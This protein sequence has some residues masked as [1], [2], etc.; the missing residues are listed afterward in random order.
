MSRFNTGLTYRVDARAMRRWNLSEN[1]LPPDTVVLF[2]P[3]SMW[4]QH[5]VFISLVVLVVGL[6]SLLM[7][8]LLF[9]RRRRREAE[10]SLRDSEARMTFTAEIGATAQLQK[11]LN[12]IAEVSGVQDA[13]RA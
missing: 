5:R 1:K 13:R 4:Q 11:A 12:A 9:Q 7:S 8:A 2:K 6:Q 10:K 3:Y